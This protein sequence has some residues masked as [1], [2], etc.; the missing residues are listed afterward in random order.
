M[1]KPGLLRHLAA[2]I[3]DFLLLV[4]LLFFATAILLPF[5]GG[6]AFS[7]QQIFYPLYLLTISFCFYGWFWTHGG[8]TLGLKAWKIKVLNNDYG[9]ISW[10]QAVVRFIVSLFSWSLLGLGFLWVLVD[11]NQRCWHDIVSKTGL[12]LES[13]SKH[14]PPLSL[15]SNHIILSNV[16]RF[17]WQIPN[18]LPDTGLLVSLCNPSSATGFLTESVLKW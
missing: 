5:N 17:H 9:L 14:W 1:T 18:S 3:Y 15:L 2:I 13:P 10:Q 6:K 8:Q 7:Q 16:F 11:K 12:F 4:A